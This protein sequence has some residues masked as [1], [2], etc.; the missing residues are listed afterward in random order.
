M[1][2]LVNATRGDKDVAARVCH[3][4]R[5]MYKKDIKFEKLPSNFAQY[6]QW[7]DTCVYDA[8]PAVGH[9]FESWFMAR[10]SVIESLNSFL[11]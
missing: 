6:G 9:R 1:S 2:R 3:Y 7:F 4:G 8:H 5:S 11:A 10:L